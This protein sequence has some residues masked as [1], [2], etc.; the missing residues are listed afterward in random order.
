MIRVGS[1]ED[2]RSITTVINLRYCGV[3]FDKGDCWLLD[4][5]SELHVD[6]ELR[7]PL[8]SPPPP[9]G[10]QQIP[11]TSPSVHPTEISPIF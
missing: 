10:G 3:G 5:D 1:M 6:P 11:P 8:R 2:F 4:N 9:D 7:Y